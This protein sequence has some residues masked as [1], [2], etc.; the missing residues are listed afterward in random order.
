MLCI[1]R[2]RRRIVLV[3]GCLTVCASAAADTI[4]LKNGRRIAAL[5]V[6]QAG[7]KISV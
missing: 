2:S 4:V 6:T 5:S 3:L 1:W 7:D